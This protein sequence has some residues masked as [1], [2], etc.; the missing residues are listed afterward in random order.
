MQSHQESDAVYKALNLR[1]KHPDIL[2]DRDHDS[3]MGRHLDGEDIID[4][5]NLGQELIRKQTKQNGSFYNDP[6]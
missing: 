1:E 2:F 3:L 6:K 5:E 4:L